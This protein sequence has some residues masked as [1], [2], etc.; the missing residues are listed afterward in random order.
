M[1]DNYYDI[2]GVSKSASQE[3]IKKA[4]KKMAI[5]YHPDK[6][7]GDKK[8]EEKFKEAAKAYDIIGDKSKREQYDRYGE[9]SF[10]AGGGQGAQF[11]DFSDIFSAF[12]DIFGGNSGTTRKRSTSVDGDDLRYDVRISL[13]EAFFGKREVIEFTAMVSCSSCSGTGS[14]SGKQDLANCS[15]CN[16]SG[17]VRTQRGFFIMENTCSKCSGSGKYVKSPCS[18]CKGMGRMNE[19]K[20]ITIDIDAGIEDG[21]RVKIPYQGEAGAR[22]GRSGDL[23]IFVN[24]KENPKFYRKSD[25]IYTNVE[26][27]ATTAMIGG[28]TDIP[29]IEGGISKLKIAAGT[30]HGSKLKMQGKGMSIRGTTG[31]KRGNMIVEVSVYIPQNLSQADIEL[32]EKLHKNISGNN[33]LG[34]KSFGGWFGSKNK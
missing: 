25:N 4:Y 27:F 1:S 16:G 33:S 3:E 31:G 19:S 9:S 34:K 32:V 11:N 29:L 30:Q 5:K 22:G 10:S 26:V 6:A 28:T 21:S 14:S 18:S 15:N 8:M 13:E 7:Q 20:R 23:Y 24:I 17:H 12:G 2:L